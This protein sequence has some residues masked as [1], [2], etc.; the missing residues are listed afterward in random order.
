MKQPR[1]DKQGGVVKKSKKALS[2]RPLIRVDNGVNI[3]GDLLKVHLSDWAESLLLAIIWDVDS[4][5]KT[6]ID[7]LHWE[8]KAHGTLFF[9]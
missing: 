3:R 9:T 6:K 8:P 7:V 1:K 5:R 2:G 4:G